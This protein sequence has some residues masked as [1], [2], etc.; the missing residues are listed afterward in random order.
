M[1]VIIFKYNLFMIK[2]KVRINYISILYIFTQC[3]YIIYSTKN[4]IKVHK[5][6]S[7]LC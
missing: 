3:K 7:S 1:L 2:A 6:S 5:R 4:N